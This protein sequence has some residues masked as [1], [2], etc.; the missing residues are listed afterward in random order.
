MEEKIKTLN[1]LGYNVVEI[2]GGFY[3]F[4]TFDPCSV[5]VF[6]TVL[7]GK[8]ITKLLEDNALPFQLDSSTV[9][10]TPS[11]IPGSSIAITIESLPSIYREYSQQYRW[12]AYLSR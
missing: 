1:R 6:K 4:A 2:D 3:I 10:Q 9:S 8:D 7:I 11:Q 12:K 5:N